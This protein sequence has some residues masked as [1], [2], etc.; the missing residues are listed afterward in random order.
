MVG[1]GELFTLFFVMLGP[2]KLLGPFAKRTRGID[3]RTVE[4]I[5]VWAFVQATVSVVV[6]G[7]LGAKLLGSWHISIPS[8]TIAGG[9]VFFLVALRQL[10]EQYERHVPDTPAEPLPASPMVAA[11]QLLFPIVLT[12]Y[13]IAAVIAV[14]GA[15]TDVARTGVILTIVL[16]IMVLDLLAMWFARRILIGPVIIGLQVLGAVLAVMQVAL[17]VE[18]IVTG[19][20]SLGVIPA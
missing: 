9:I 4:R 11:T 13:G 14:M 8:M 5:A 16:A 17:A 15:S 7:V 19:L 18:L 3:D 1:P 20:K 10:L 12:P 6:G 2:L